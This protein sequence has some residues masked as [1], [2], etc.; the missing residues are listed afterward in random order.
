VTAATA[1]WL[2]VAAISGVANWWSRWARHRPTELWSKPLTLAAL[3]AAAVALD[4]ADPAVRAWFVVALALSLAGDVLLLGGDRWFVAG[5]AAFLAAHLA[6]VCGFAVADE[7]RWW[8][9]G[10]AAVALTVVAGVVGR[11]IVA[12]ATARRAAL[13]IPVA[14]YLAVICAMVAAAAAAGDGWAIA[15]ALLFLVSDAVLGWRQ[16]VAESRWMPLAIMVTY[17]VGQAGLV[18]SLAG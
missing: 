4:P 13:R 7:W 2:V 17:H 9:F 11:R 3:I 1:V 16:F 14:A 10:L 8:A 15:G 5:L 18:L 6:Y 12:G